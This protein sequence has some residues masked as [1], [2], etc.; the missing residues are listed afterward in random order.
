MRK[1]TWI[2]GT[3]AVL[4]FGLCPAIA[5]A[6]SEVKGSGVKM[7]TNGAPDGGNLFSHISVHAWLDKQGVAHGKVTWEGDLFQPLPGGQTGFHGGPSAPFLIDVTEIIFYGNIAR[8]IGVVV[9]SP[10]KSEEGTTY[11]FLFTD[12][13][14][15]DAPDEIDSVPIDAGNIIVR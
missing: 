12:N 1:T 9:S 14:A 3:L 4:L 13:I 10:N 6:Q 2:R 5:T 11:S 8:V 7:F 15:T